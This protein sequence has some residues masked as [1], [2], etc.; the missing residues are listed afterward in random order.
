[1]RAPLFIGLRA[2]VALMVVLTAAAGVQADSTVD[3]LF[4]H[5]N[6]Q[7]NPANTG[8]EA[9]LEI[10]LD[11]AVTAISVVAT[12]PGGAIALDHDLGSHRWTAVA[13]YADSSAGLSSLAADLTGNFNITV[14]TTTG[15]S[16]MAFTLGNLNLLQPSSFMA[17]PQITYPTNG[18]SGVAAQPTFTWNPTADL[19]GAYVISVTMNSGNVWDDDNNIP[20]AGG[21]M[22]INDTSWQSE[23]VLP[24]GPALFGV[25]YGTS[26]AA[27]VGTFLTGFGTTDEGGVNWITSP[28]APPGYPSDGTPL[29]ALVSEDRI[30]FDAVPEPASMALLAMSGIALLR[31][32]AA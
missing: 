13:N 7:A 19:A 3:M 15:V 30:G 27:Y 11:N 31:R 5:V 28:F 12:G 24:G 25:L 14:T 23:Q 8:Y 16:T 6:D 18:Q 26:N 22:S 9:V 4:D 1:M 10:A 21:T 32:R 29:L 2:L 17:L 20:G